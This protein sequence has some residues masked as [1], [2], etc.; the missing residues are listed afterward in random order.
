MNKNNERKTKKVNW[1]LVRNI[2]IPIATLTAGIIAGGYLKDI[3]YKKILDECEINA[4]DCW[5]MG[6]KTNEFF[7]LLSPEMRIAEK[8]PTQIFIN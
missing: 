3:H 5:E 6:L 7:E 4:F 2:A 1:V 8:C